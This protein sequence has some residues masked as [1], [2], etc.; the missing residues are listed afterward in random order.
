[1]TD[2]SRASISVILTPSSSA[3]QADPELPTYSPRS[4]TR[5]TEQAFKLEDSKSCAWLWLKVKSRSR[6]NQLPLFFDR[7]TLSGTIEVDFDKAGGA[8]AV[9]VSVS[10]PFSQNYSVPCFQEA[11]F[12][13]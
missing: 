6:E 9:T 1:M 2:N 7:D 3:S 11:V 8:I 10:Y 4:Q 13:N 12:R 5:D